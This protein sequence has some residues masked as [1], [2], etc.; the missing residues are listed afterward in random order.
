L[1]S[2]AGGDVA[3][4]TPVIEA[5]V[6]TAQFRL[7]RFERE[8]AE[9]CAEHRKGGQTQRLTIVRRPMPQG[10]VLLPLSYLP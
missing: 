4:P 1:S 10:P 9:R 6:K 3:D 8:E 5:A 2:H 7:S